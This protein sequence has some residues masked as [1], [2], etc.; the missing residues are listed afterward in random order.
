MRATV[1]MRHGGLEELEYRSDWPDPRPGPG[2]AILRV[3]ACTLNYHDVFTRRGMPGIKVPLPLIVGID[4][5]G[6]IVELG[7]EVEGF[8]VGDRVLV[9]PIDRVNGG[10]TGET[11]DGGLAEYVRIPAHQLVPLDPA[12]P[13]AEA[14]ALPVA[15]GT[16]YRMMVTRGRLRAGETVLIL[17]A[18]GGVGTC[19]VQLAKQAGCTVAV[20]ASS[21]AKLDRLRA[22]GADHG[23]DYAQQDWVKACQ[24]LFGKARVFGGAEGGLDVVV[25][26]TGGDTWTK[27]LRVLRKDGRLLTCGA[28]AGYDP[29]EDIRF[30][31]TFELNIIGSNGWS[32]EDVL[33]LLDLVK[34][35]RLTPVLHPERFGLEGAREAM[36]LLDDRAVM[37]KVVIEP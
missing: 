1:L 22:L 34:A 35:G 16:A 3:R 32:R 17:G 7:A 37:G 10:L 8:R 36:R 14:A 25:N 31:W 11:Y 28:T 15:Y 20:A 5:A 19:C 2:D 24:A 30:I 27:S 26:F 33:A 4:V 29:P 21:P 23:I 12:I 18:S 6:E 9:D 13:F